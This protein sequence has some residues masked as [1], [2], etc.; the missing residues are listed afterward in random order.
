LAVGGIE[1][2]NQGD[3]VGDEDEQGEG[4]DEREVGLALVAHGL[5][6]EI[7]HTADHDF[8]EILQTAGDH[9]DR[10]RGGESEQDE[11]EH[12]EPGV[13]HVFAD[14]NAKLLLKPLQK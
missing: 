11:D 14:V 1:A 6:D 13:H 7:F 5:F 10:P 2:G 9:L 3:Q 12:D 8:H 4:G